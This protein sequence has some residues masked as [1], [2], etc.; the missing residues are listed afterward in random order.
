MDHI[1]ILWGSNFHVVYVSL[2]VFYYLQP[3]ASYLIYLTEQFKGSINSQQNENH[4]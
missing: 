4:S 1:A 3:K 2:L